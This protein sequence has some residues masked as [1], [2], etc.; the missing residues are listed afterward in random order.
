MQQWVD[1]DPKIDDTVTLYSRQFGETRIV[2]VPKDVFT[3]DETETTYVL[4]FKNQD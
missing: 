2:I 4:T 1:C 3:L